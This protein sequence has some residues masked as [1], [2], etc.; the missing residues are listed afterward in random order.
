MRAETP[1]EFLEDG[2]PLT[3]IHE[4]A[5]EVIDLMGGVVASTGDDEIRFLLGERRNLAAGNSVEC[6][7]S[8]TEEAGGSLLLRMEK[9]VSPPRGQRLLLLIT[10]TLGAF[11][12]LLWPFFPGMGAASWIGGAVAIGTYF[13][14]L[15]RTPIGTG[16]DLIQRIAA[17]QRSEGS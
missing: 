3:G 13:V 12:W 6:R 10:G 16:A 7:L 8:W 17:R 2:V 11:L 15:R 14:A 1:I 4:T 9:E 5:V